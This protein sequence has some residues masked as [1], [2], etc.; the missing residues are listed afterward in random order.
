MTEPTS[1][2][3][4]TTRPITTRPITKL[5][6][7]NRGE[8]AVR[9]ARTARRMGIATVGIYAEPDANA[10]HVDSV[11]VAIALGG[12]SPAESY[13][14]GDAVIRAAL[15]TGADAIHPGYGFLAENA[16]FAQQVTDA[17]L[18]WVG[19]TPAQIS[20]LGDKVA[21][22]TAAVD[23]GVPTTTVTEASPDSVPDNVAMPALV[24]AAAGGGGRG[25]R[26]V[27]SQDD[28]AE[29]VTAAARE[30]LSAFGDGTVFIEPYI[31]NGRHVEVQIMGDAHGNV[32][33]LGERE[34]SIQRRNQK[35]IEESPSPGISPE[36]RAALT[37]GALALARHIGYENAG[38]VEFLVGDDGTINFLEVNTRLQVEHPVT[39]AVTGLDLVEMQLRVAS[40]EELSVTQDDIIITGHAIEVRLVAEDPTTGWL[41][42]VGTVERFAMGDGVRVDSGIG[43]GD[44]ISPSYD[45]LIAK[46]ISHAGD[47]TA[48]AGI[49][50]QG[51][52]SG[53]VSGVKTN[54]NAMVALLSEPDF[55]AG[56]TPTSY[57]DNH[58]EIAQAGGP[59][60]HERMA[61]LLAAAFAT[62]Y[63]RRS[64]DGITPFAR[65]GWRLV[66]TQGQRQ[67][68]LLDDKA[69][70]VEY[71]MCEDNATVLVGDLP[72]PDSDGV[73]APDDRVRADVRILRRTGDKVAIE[74]NGRRHVVAVDLDGDLA[75]TSSPAGA[76]TW[77]LAPR[78]EAHDTESQ[79]SGPVCP[80]PGTVIEVNV[81]PGQQVSDG[82]VL[83]VVEAMKM[84]HK[85]TATGSAIVSEV[86]FTVG[87][88]VD[89]GVLLVAFE[90]SDE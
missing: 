39:E 71:D 81:L 78:F 45:S 9:I 44:T 46:V 69:H 49:L 19:P 1:T 40:G 35:V 36:I 62:D 47:R 17:G 21:A 74:V 7:A 65:S 87:D 84:E 82:D 70:T 28:L 42:S 56:A 61:L 27:R 4:I 75:H 54:L 29:A 68:W 59:E 85:I 23:A 25:M 50:A 15:E 73:L 37:D 10:L 6:I 16:E 13:L 55:L 67:T 2:R 53:Q 58:P 41:P 31:E 32:V 89:Q 3:P 26:I 66:H 83:V 80:L 20:L 48:A 90:E 5:L 8:I 30:A 60:G 34:C 76:I 24:K 64:S 18:I 79:G 43:S 38:T 72:V 57:L 11:D 88:R 22:K 51:L 63:A 33:H 77:T 52:R 14:R 86:F 12:S